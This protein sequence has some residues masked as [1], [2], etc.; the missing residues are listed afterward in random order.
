MAQGVQTKVMSVLM[1]TCSHADPN[2]C[3][4]THT[5]LVPSTVFL[6][7][8]VPASV[9]VLVGDV[10]L[11][12]VPVVGCTSYSLLLS[13]IATVTTPSCPLAPSPSRGHLP[14]HSPP[15]CLPL[16]F[17][18]L[19]DVRPK[20]TCPLRQGYFVYDCF[21]VLY[22]FHLDGMAYFVHGFLCLVL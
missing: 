17:V 22:H 7:G 12:Q 19:T 13:A 16:P 18:C 20:T 4:L 14:V 5:G 11:V 9:W 15:L 1:C 2:I 8:I 3:S 6:A 10:D 21:V